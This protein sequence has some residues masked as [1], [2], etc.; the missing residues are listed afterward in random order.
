MNRNMRRILIGGLICGVIGVI[1]YFG[2]TFIAPYSLIVPLRVDPKEKTSI[3]H[4]SQLS[5]PYDTLNIH[6]DD[7]T[8]LS[9]YWIQAADSPRAI[10]ICLH[11]I[12][13]VKEVNLKLAAWLHEQQIASIL[14]DL[15]AHGT[16][17]GTFN[18]YGF[19][20]KQDISAV[21]QYIKHQQPDVAIGIWGTSL[22]GAIGLQTLAIEPDLDFGV[23]NST[24]SHLPQIISDYQKGYFGGIRVP[25]LTRYAMKK[26]GKIADFD[27]Y[28][29]HPVEAA[30]QISQPIMMVHGTADDNIDIRYGQENFE[31]LG[32]ADKVFVPIAGANH[33]NV[34]QV[35]GDSL[36]AV[37]KAFLDR[38]LE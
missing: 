28:S 34:P 38:I 29:V 15:R 10:I 11:G 27:L 9:G 12:S 4:P 26:A 25:A 6:V 5:L 20:E 13:A 2:V 24:F 35:G 32:S 1:T 7:S 23:I 30:K 8:R 19:R 16:S 21:V 3:Y 33:Y 36:K 18:T 17:G 14:L 31:Q 37:Y 22:G